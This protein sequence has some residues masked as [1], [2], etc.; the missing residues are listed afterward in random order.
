VI[1]DSIRKYVYYEEKDIVLLHGDCWKILNEFH[2]DYCNLMLTDPPYGILGGSKSVGG[3]KL[4]EA[5]QYDLSW[6]NKLNEM[7]INR[8]LDL[9]LKHI[10]WG[11]NYYA[12]KLPN[13]NSLLIWDKKTKNDWN[14][15]FSDGEIAW[16]NI[17]NPLRIYRHLW[18]GCLQ[19]KGEKRIHPTQKPVELMKWCLGFA[20]EAETILDPFLG[21]GT[22]AVAAKNLGRKCIGIEIEEKYLKIAKERLKQEVL[23]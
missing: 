11:Y 19:T 1:P 7:Q 20:P 15:N 22:T 5:N 6:D 17:K 10:I 21:S 12:D 8:L 14:D 23:F 9:A 13:T 4:V 18:M 3:S 16:T 2:L